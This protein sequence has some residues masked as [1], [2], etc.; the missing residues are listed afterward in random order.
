MTFTPLIVRNT[1]G[2]VTLT[3]RGGR[4]VFAFPTAAQARAFTLDVAWAPVLAVQRYENM[5]AHY[6]ALHAC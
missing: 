3:T 2:P 1:P 6:T 5:R 4:A